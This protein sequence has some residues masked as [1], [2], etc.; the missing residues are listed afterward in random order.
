[1]LDFFLRLHHEYPHFNKCLISMHRTGY[2]IFKTKCKMKVWAT[3]ST[4]TKNFKAVKAELK[5]SS[6]PFCSMF[7]KP[8]LSTSLSVYNAFV[9]LCH[10]PDVMFIL[11]R[12]MSF[13]FMRESLRERK[14]V[15]PRDTCL[16]LPQKTVC[17]RKTRDSL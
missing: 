16:F 3:F 17:K 4:I 6:R 11:H 8:T 1:M 15:C 14:H 12:E 5:P 2:V 7:T 13:T 10:S 9:G